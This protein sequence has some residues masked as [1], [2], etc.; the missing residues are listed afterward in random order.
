MSIK[1]AIILAAGQGTRLRPFTDNIPKCMVKV[2]GKPMLEWQIEVLN[3]CG[4]D[5]ITVITGYK[6]DQITDPRVQKVFNPEFE[7][8]NMI[9]SLMCAENDFFGDVILAYGDI[10]YSKEVLQRLLSGK[11]D[12]VLAS[13]E[14]W[15]SY[16]EKRFDDPLSDAETFI[17]NPNR[18]VKSLG[19]KAESVDQVQGQFTGL[20]KF[21]ARGCERLKEA[22]YECKND[23]T[24]KNNSWDSGRDLRNAYM[25]DILNYLAIKSDVYYEPIFRGWFEVDD[26]DDL[27]IANREFEE[28][29][30]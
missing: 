2:N 12:I 29:I 23:L 1:K 8:T 18:L 7:S 25:T 6:E 21:S 22:Y 5:E 19:Q 16:W 27:E 13:D 17:T 4:V 11:G 9:Y 20:M 3:I 10:I 24:C 30:G 26:A 14:K 28:I 15:H